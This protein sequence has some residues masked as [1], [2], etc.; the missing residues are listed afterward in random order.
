MSD[1]FETPPNHPACWR[2][3]LVKGE[4]DLAAFS[5][6]IE[7]AGQAF[8]ED[9]RIR[10][11]VVDRYRKEAGKWPLQVVLSAHICAPTFRLTSALYMSPTT[12]FGLLFDHK[13]QMERLFE[14]QSQI[15]NILVECAAEAGADFVMHAI[16]G[17]E[18]FS[19]TIYQ[20]YFIPQARDLH[21][22]AHSHGLRGWVHTCGYMNKLIGLGVYE[23]MNVDVLESLS[24]PPLG[25]LLDLKAGRAK[26]GRKI[27]TRGAVG[28]DQ[29]YSTDIGAIRNRVR[30]VLE[31]TRGYRHMIGDT[32]DSFP[33]YPREN[34]MATVDEVRKSG[35]YLPA[36]HTYG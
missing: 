20:E 25:D 14:A 24:P 2:E 21:E 9:Q 32:N 31:S 18:I 3:H 5:Y 34:I 19:P 17:L 22:K 33:P 28:V 7:H 4:D 23:A 26:I 13:A 35:R 36:Q 6:L 1:L 29:F 27:T 8:L 11:Y 15:N 16:N 12:A 10:E 30:Y